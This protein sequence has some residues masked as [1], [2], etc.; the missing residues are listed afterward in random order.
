MEQLGHFL[1][2]ID[3]A[4]LMNDNF[5]GRL[6]CMHC[7]QVRGRN[8]LQK[9]VGEAFPCPMLDYWHVRSVRP[10]R[11]ILGRTGVAPVVGDISCM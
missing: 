7:H 11:P 5:S 1:R 9:A 4:K 3:R 10:D 2:P 8:D 6:K